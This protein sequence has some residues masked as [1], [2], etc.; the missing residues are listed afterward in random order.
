MHIFPFFQI[1]IAKKIF[2]VFLNL[3][4][5]VKSGEFSLFLDHFLSGLLQKRF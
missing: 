1:H 5:D 3:F 4:Y 2:F